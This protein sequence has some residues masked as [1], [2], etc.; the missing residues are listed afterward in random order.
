MLCL[1]FTFRTVSNL[2]LIVL[3]TKY[4]LTYF[5]SKKWPDE[6]VNA[7]RLVLWEQ[8]TTYYKPSDSE[9]PGSDG[10]QSSAS[11][12]ELVSFNTFH[13]KYMVDL[14]IY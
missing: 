1:R 5:R 13:L 12:S 6:W 9:E 7:A 2:N 14:F 4:K 8:W 11:N 3:H 10:S